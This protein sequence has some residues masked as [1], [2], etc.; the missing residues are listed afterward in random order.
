MHQWPSGVASRNLE[1]WAQ[2]FRDR[3][4]RFNQYDFGEPH[5]AARLLL[6]WVQGKGAR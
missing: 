5:A 2:L 4:V 1:H 6:G 3:R